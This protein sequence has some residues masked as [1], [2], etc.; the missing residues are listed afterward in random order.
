MN[1]GCQTLYNLSIKPTIDFYFLYFSNS[2]F[3]DE[4]AK[5]VTCY[6]YQE[7]KFP[8]DHTD[9][10]P[11][12]PAASSQNIKVENFKYL[13]R[14]STFTGIA[15]YNFELKNL[16][17]E[18]FVDDTINSH[19]DSIRVYKSNGTLTFVDSIMYKGEKVFIV[20]ILT[21]DISGSLYW[22]RDSSYYDD[23][24]SSQILNSSANN[25]SIIKDTIQI[26]KSCQKESGFGIK[27]EE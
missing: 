2:T 27:E 16:K 26:N 19:I 10:L 25:Y 7:S 21:T 13:I 6:Y 23:Y 1:V 24:K 9:I 11:L 14:D 22:N 17:I 18:S 20:E 5:Y 8:A 15:K 3:I 12:L 4:I